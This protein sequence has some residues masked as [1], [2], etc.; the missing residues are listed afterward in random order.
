MLHLLDA[1]SPLPP[2]LLDQ[3]GAFAW[4]YADALDARGDGFV[5]IWSWGLPF[6]PGLAAAD[7]AGRPTPPAARPSL[8]LAWYERF[9]PV[10]YLLQEHPAE[11]A[12]CGEG[13]WRFG[14]TAIHRT[15]DGLH[16]ALDCALPG[17]AERLRGTIDLSGPAYAGA[18]AF[19][20]PAA[21]SH[22]WAPQL[23]PAR[24]L[25]RLRVGER[26]F[27][28]AGPAYADR[29]HGDRP[30]HRLGLRRWTWARA[31]FGAETR[32]AY[33]LW[34]EGGG[35]P[36]AY[37]I[38]VDAGGRAT[39]QT[40]A[41]RARRGWPTVW[42]MRPERCLRVEVDGAPFL[43]LEVGRPVDS[44]PFYQRAL[45]VGRAPDGRRAPVVLESCVPGRVDPGWMRPLVRMAV[46][47]VAGGASRW[48]PLFVGPR[49][50]RWGRLLRGWR[51]TAPRLT[52]ATG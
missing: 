33:L 29:N 1:G 25:A 43:E 21:A 18:D 26:H 49:E 20:E 32:V 22:G 2:G 30:L 13:A 23:G 40:G 44:S 48:A 12:R 28:Y 38:R 7:R 9:R 5:L 47:P 10:L 15:A 17:T 39:V 37:A 8:N 34:P 19:W 3:P 42:G 14:D 41:V 36:T 35:A 6:L 31:T 27:A 52:A 50:G 16:L 11:D 46:H 4:W 45:G 24:A 51:G